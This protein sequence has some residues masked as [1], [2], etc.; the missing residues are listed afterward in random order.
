MDPA[1]VGK[2]AEDFGHPHPLQNEKMHSNGIF[3]RVVQTNSARGSPILEKGDV[4]HFFPFRVFF[5]RVDADA[6][7]GI[8]ERDDRGC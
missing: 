2:R 1:L 4:R 8:H 7:V 5:V 3:A 6:R